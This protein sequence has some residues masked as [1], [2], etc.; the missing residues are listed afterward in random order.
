MYP[1]EQVR[2]Q[3]AANLAARRSHAAACDALADVL[4]LRPLTVV[5]DFRPRADVMP[6]LACKVRLDYC[7]LD[8]VYIDAQLRD[9][10]WVANPA[11]ESRLSGTYDIRALLHKTS[12]AELLLII[13]LPHGDAPQ[14]EAA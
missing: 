12:G 6:T 7:G 1:F 10:G 9:L 14:W 5:T 2:T 4:R 11:Q 8:Q 3:P 13:T